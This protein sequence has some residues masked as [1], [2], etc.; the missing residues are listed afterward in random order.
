MR[1]LAVLCLWLG[2]HMHAYPQEYTVQ[3][4]TMEQGLPADVVYEITQD[5]DGYIWLTTANG[6]CRYDGFVFKEYAN[7]HIFAED[8]PW[9]FNYYGEIYVLTWSG[10]LGRIKNDSLQSFSKRDIRLGIRHF[11]RDRR[12]GYWLETG[13]RGIV[14]IYGGKIESLGKQ[15]V[16]L[17]EDKDGAIYGYGQGFSYYDA[18]KNKFIPI[19]KTKTV[20]AY[21]ILGGVLIFEDEEGRCAIYKNMDLRKKGFAFDLKR[22]EKGK[23]LSI[24]HLLKKKENEYW[25]Q[26]YKNILV[27]D[28]SGN[29][30]ENI[31]QQI[32]KKNLRI[33]TFFVDREENIWVGTQGQGLFLLE[34]KPV[35]NDFPVHDTY[36]SQLAG[37]KKGDIAMAHLGG[38]ISLLDRQGGYHTY[39]LPGPSIYM[40]YGLHLWRDNLLGVWE[41]SIFYI[42]EKYRIHAK[43]IPVCPKNIGAE[44]T[45]RYIHGGFPKEAA[46]PYSFQK[47]RDGDM[48]VGTNRGLYILPAGDTP[49]FPYI[50]VHDFRYAYMTHHK[51]GW[52]VDSRAYLGKGYKIDIKRTGENTDTYISQLLADPRGVMWVATQSE[53]LYANY[54]GFFYHFT[55]GNGLLSNNINSIYLDKKN[56]LWVCSN[57]G[58]T[59]I[60]PQ[61]QIQYITTEDG[62]RSN[63]VNGVFVSD[64]EKAYLGT[65]KGLSML[66]LNNKTSFTPYPPI[67]SKIEINDSMT[68]LGD[69]NQTLSYRENNICVEYISVSFGHQIRYAYFVEGLS[70]D[71]EITDERSIYLPRLT[72]GDYRLKIKALGIDG[73]ESKEV[74]LAQFSIA[75]PFWKRTVFWV[76]ISVLAGTLIYLAGYYRKKRLV[77]QLQ[78]RQKI[79]NLEKKALLSQI[80]PHFV[81]N[82]LTAIK[83]LLSKGEIDKTDEYIQKFATLMRNTLDYSESRLISLS[84]EVAYIENYLMLEELRFGQTF[85]YEITKEESIN[86]EAYFLPPMLLQPYIENAI[87]HGLRPKKKGGKLSIF[88]YME[89]EHLCVSIDD[90]GVGR[91]EAARLKE[92]NMIH[93]Q[94]KGMHISS[95]RAFLQDIQVSVIDK[96]T[97]SRESGG[98]RIVLKIPQ[99]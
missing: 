14:H 77:E 61:G 81:F 8:M 23:V 85:G 74:I 17:Y 28:S 50:S 64:D 5:R 88:F 56:R 68:R 29:L 13:A 53:G 30:L 90:N 6:L 18:E 48:W 65:A 3:D 62:I 38:K 35:K 2:I 98:T 76:G 36:I 33:N 34:K 10:K 70:N 20:F 75:A 71:W 78:L 26:D 73:L 91:K 95:Q 83:Y 1:Y 93:Y 51:K 57:K 99:T 22:D 55:K 94:S 44:G 69:S 49:R 32:P 82:C 42:D 11:L 21:T 15:T 92:K 66:D 7:Q 31:T 37:N 79:N 46:A 97:E 63:Q 96:Q 54:K 4:Y 39:T 86:P 59:C 80:N 67:L 45:D 43:R 41:R 9:L 72:P 47:N 24:R 27:Y 12:G 40:F 84:E 16:R 25:V 87:R 89:G 60:G 58:V 52:E 19:K